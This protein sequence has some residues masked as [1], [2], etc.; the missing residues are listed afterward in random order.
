MEDVDDCGG[1]HRGLGF[2]RGSLA[3]GGYLA[4]QGGTGLGWKLVLAW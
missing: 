3:L 1:E 2:A 4:R